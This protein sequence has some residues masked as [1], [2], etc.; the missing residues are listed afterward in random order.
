MGI[1]RGVVNGVCNR[2]TCASEDNIVFFNHSTR[3]YYCVSC[4]MTLNDVNR[5]DAHKLYQHDLCLTDKDET[6][7]QYIKNKR[8]C[9]G[10]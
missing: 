7:K 5:K 1:R 4:A 9:H 6:P 10:T 2:T 8:M 3:K